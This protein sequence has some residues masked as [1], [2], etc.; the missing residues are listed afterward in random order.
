MS[1]RPHFHFSC[2]LFPLP[3]SLDLVHCSLSCL[4]SFP[5]P[6]SSLFSFSPFPDLP[7]SC[8]FIALVFNIF[9]YPIYIFL[10]VF[11]F[12]K[13]ISWSLS[14]LSWKMSLR[15][16]AHLFTIS[17][18]KC[19]DCSHLRLLCC[20]LCHDLRRSSCQSMMKCCFKC[21]SF[22]FQHCYFYLICAMFP[23]LLLNFYF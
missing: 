22:F 11:S 23:K 8:V 10:L 2:C 6:C 3:F 15:L 4:C 17:T 13:K 18:L 14:F 1:L 7:L 21:L 20:S 9:V 5:F 16:L 19:A 12:F